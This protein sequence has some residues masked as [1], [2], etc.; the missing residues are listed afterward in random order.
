MVTVQAGVVNG[1]DRAVAANSWKTFNVSALLKTAGGTLV[2][3]N[4]YGGPHDT[5]NRWFFD[6][7]A[8][9]DIGKFSVNLNGAFGLEGNSKWYGAALMA[10]FNILD[11]LRVSGRV[12]YFG[13]PDGH[14]L[15]ARDASYVNSTLGLAYAVTGAGSVEIRPEVRHD[16]SLNG[17]PYV[18]GT[19]DMQTT[20]QLAML[21]WF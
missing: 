18:G 12:E 19:N 20:V 21:A 2:A 7:V 10:K 3:L 16:Q 14:R 4:F 8:Q 5:A 15:G 17:T 9:Q 11:S 6:L 13:D 1:W